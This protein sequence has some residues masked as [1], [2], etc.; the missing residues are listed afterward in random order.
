M[1]KLILILAA[2]A[3]CAA[4]TAQTAQTLEEI[5][6]QGT[7]PRI[8]FPAQLHDVW[9]DQFDTV[10]GTYYLSDG[11]TMQLSMWGNRMYAKIDGMSKVQLVA[12]S[13][14]VFVARDL[15]MK[16][17]IDDP[18]ASAGAIRATVMLAGPRLSSTAG[19]DGFVTL[20]ARR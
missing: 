16:I 17:M 6:V 8:E 9:Y 3:L 20:V 14:Y 1:K 12:A 5:R 7:Q 19:A 4:A 18:E 10:K 11:K 2:G 15:R 13:P